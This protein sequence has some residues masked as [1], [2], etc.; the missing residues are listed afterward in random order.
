MLDSSPPRNYDAPS[1][2]FSGRSY[3]VFQRG[4][5]SHYHAR[6]ANQ[7]QEGEEKQPA[8]GS[9]NTNELSR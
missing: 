1:I 9:K 2:A 6:Q 3:Q 7:E 5:P 4:E 8:F